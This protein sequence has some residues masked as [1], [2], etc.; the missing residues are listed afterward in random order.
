MKQ[1][2][3]MVC[4]FLTIPQTIVWSETGKASDRLTL[5]VFNQQVPPCHLLHEKWVQQ[6]VFR[7]TGPHFEEGT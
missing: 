1:K 4:S 6:R 2:I 5:P 7:H 3:K